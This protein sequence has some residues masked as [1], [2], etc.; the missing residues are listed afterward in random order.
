MEG[1]QYLST[2]VDFCTTGM[3][4]LSSGSVGVDIDVAVDSEWEMAYGVAGGKEMGV[5][6]FLFRS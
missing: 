5:L 6:I 2:Q 4:M 1:A 3:I